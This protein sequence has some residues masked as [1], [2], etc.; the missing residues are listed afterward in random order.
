MSASSSGS[1][2]TGAFGRAM[3]AR[4]PEIR[5]KIKNSQ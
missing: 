2:W 4:T 1:R 3:L 5:R